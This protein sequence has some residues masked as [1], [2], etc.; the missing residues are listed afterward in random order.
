M[1]VEKMGEA[2]WT[3]Y[4]G[5]IYGNEMHKACFFPYFRNALYGIDTVIERL[6]LVSHK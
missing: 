6:N 3:L 2:E 1:I 5:K 4:Q